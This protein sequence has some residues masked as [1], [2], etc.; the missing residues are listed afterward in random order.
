M[1][2]R[3]VTIDWKGNVYPVV[4]CMDRFGN[5]TTEPTEIAAAIMQVGPND[6]REVDPA[7]VPIYTVH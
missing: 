2:I 7:E 1:S 4:N 3:Y 5:D 6:W